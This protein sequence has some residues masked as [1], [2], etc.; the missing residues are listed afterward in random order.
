VVAWPR[1]R[2][3]P[4]RIAGSPPST[5][6]RSAL[7]PRRPE[8]GTMLRRPIVAVCALALPVPAAADAATPSPAVRKLQRQVI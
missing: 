2:L 4:A 6:P 8:E 1:A 3:G 5:R 7:E